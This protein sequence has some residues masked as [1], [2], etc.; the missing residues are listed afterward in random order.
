MYIYLF[1]SFL[2]ISELTFGSILYG[3]NHLSEVREL[4][5]QS[6]L[7]ACESEKLLNFIENKDL[8]QDSPVFLAYLGS[9]Q[10]MMADCVSMPHKKM[11]YFKQGAENLDNAVSQYRNNFEIRFLRLQ[12]QIHSPDFLKYKSNIAEDKKIIIQHFES[13][14]QTKA[15]DAY[16]KYLAKSLQQTVK[17]NVEEKQIIQ[18]IVTD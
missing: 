18:K 10:A 7:E 1:Y 17:L 9:S 8:I 3:Q 5:K 13:A 11:S 14:L 15:V 16:T 2:I 4:Y 6:T 12:I